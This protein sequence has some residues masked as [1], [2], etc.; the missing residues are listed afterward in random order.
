MQRADSLYVDARK[1]AGGAVNAL[2]QRFSALL[3]ATVE[4]IMNINLLVFHF[5]FV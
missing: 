3:F 1:I 2:K 5:Q 4:D